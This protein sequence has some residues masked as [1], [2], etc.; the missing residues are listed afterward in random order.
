M[1]GANLNT[2]EEKKPRS[3]AQKIFFKK[4]TE[5]NFYLKEGSTFQS[6]K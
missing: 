1:K 4:I 6:T 3:K 5:K 2:V